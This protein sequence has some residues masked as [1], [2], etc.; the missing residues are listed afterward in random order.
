MAH[1]VRR[2]LSHRKSIVVAAI[3]ALVLA[4]PSPMTGYQLDD[5]LHHLKLSARAADMGDGAPSSAMFCL[6]D[7]EPQHTRP[8]VQSGFLPWW[9]LD[10]VR[11][12]FWRPL[13]VLTHVLD[14]SLW[15]DSYFMMHLHSLAWFGLAVLMAGMVYRRL[16][17]PTWAAGLAALLFA[18]DDAHAMPA[19]WLADR[20]AAIALFWGLLALWSHMRW[21]EEGRSEWL[22]LS[23]SGL[24]LS[25]LSKE[26]GISTC[27]YLAA[28]AVF[29]DPGR[30]T[31]RILSLLP[32]AGVALIW[33]LLYQGL[34]YGV[35]GSASCC[36]PVSAPGQFALLALCRAPVLFLGQWGLP[37]SDLH[38]ALPEGGQWLLWFAGVLL[39]VVLAVV[40][41]PMARTDARIRFWSVG[42]G[43]SLLAACASLPS[44]RLL[45]WPG[46]GA[47]GL[48]GQYLHARAERREIW[49]RAEAARIL[50]PPLTFL[51]IS[52]HV[53]LAPLLLP[54]RILAFATLGDIIEESVVAAPLPSD[55]ENRTVIFANAP[56]VYFT[57]YFPIIRHVLALPVPAR[58]RTLSANAPLP[59]PHDIARI[60]EKT[61]RVTPRGGFAWYLMRD[62]AHPFSPGDTIDLG[63]IQV[64]ITAVTRQGRP[65]EV[66]Y[67]FET[68]VDDPRYVWLVYKANQGQFA[69]FLPPPL[70]QVFTTDPYL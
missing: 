2:G 26:E 69:P 40:F 24:V 13:A 7:G 21:R 60:N 48:L 27:A 17:A 1:P 57:S 31:R 41:V 36:D 58:V 56:N 6:A 4:A 53:V 14:H 67:H 46:I 10:T 39:F 62:N 30:L 44:D 35:T 43:L 33:R 45:L 34:G 64:E 51:L 28:Y 55:V 18:I 59:Q 23:V 68:S 16:L 70:G 37:P 52:V 19:G 20:S 32:Y 50:A 15:P 63:D 47:C 42:L 11:L 3:L 61:L 66:E 8:L 12:S 65:K 29:L 22:A 54:M 25:L 49:S 5:W 38:L 9:T